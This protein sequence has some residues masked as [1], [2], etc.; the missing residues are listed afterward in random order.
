MTRTQLRRVLLAL[1]NVN[2]L[3]PPEL[4]ARREGCDAQE[5]SLPEV[6]DPALEVQDLWNARMSTVTHVYPSRVR[7]S[8]SCSAPASLVRS[9]IPMK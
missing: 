6:P 5:A 2:D 9:E 1:R 3:E 8:A 7:T 4:L